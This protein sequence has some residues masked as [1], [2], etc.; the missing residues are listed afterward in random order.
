[1]DVDVDVDVDDLWN[2]AFD[3]GYYNNTTVDIRD[4]LSEDVY[5]S[6]LLASSEQWEAFWKSLKQRAS[7]SNLREDTPLQQRQRRRLPLN[8]AID[9]FWE[10]I[11]L[12]AEAALR[13]EPQAGPQLYQAILSQ[14]TLLSAICTVVSHEIESELIPATAL[15]NLFMEL[16]SRHPTSF[17]RQNAA[18]GKEALG[19]YTPS[20]EEYCIR[21]D[22]QAVARRDSSVV[23]AMN[24]VLFHNGFHALVCYRVAHC[25]WQANRT[26]LAYYLQSTVSRVYSADIHPAC[27]MGS[28]IYLRVGAGVVLGETAVVE[29][30][31]S[32]LEGV[33]LGGTG[34]EAG[35]RH[36]KVGHGVIIQDGAAVLGNIRVGEGAVIT[37][38]SIVTKSVPPLAIVSGVPAKV[39]GVRMLEQPESEWDDLE[40]S[41]ISKYQT[42]WKALYD[43]VY[44]VN[45]Q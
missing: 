24:A 7:L 5:R 31:V 12:E 29:N 18:G 21:Q 16:L 22:L 1:V 19:A 39:I 13:V 3:T 11:K 33:T 28:G 27:T 25:L 42:E 4:T 17:D 37:A 30:D 6:R 14:P 44:S 34:K 2:A 26:A 35:D 8:S 15:K 40:R 23:H 38:K 41:L 20:F 10:Q 43:E 45:A 32:I 36:P 9:P